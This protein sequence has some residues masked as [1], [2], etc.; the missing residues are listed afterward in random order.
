MA[1]PKLIGIPL[2]AGR[3]LDQLIR[4]RVNIITAITPI[5]IRI[6][7]SMAI[8]PFLSFAYPPVAVLAIL[9]PIPDTFYCGLLAA[10]KII[11]IIAAFM[12][13]N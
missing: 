6:T 8:M 13:N 3:G 1:V 7:I 10:N 4:I 9:N 12:P 11:Q 2:P 5:R